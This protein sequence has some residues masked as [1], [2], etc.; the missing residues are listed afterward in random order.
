[1]ELAHLIAFNLALLVAIASPGPSLLLLTRTSVIQ[2][3]RTGIA[4]ALG[5]GL[6][7]ALW[8]LAA[9]LGLDGLFRLFPWAYAGLKV[10]GACVLL[11][12]AWTAWRSART[13]VGTSPSHLPSRHRAFLTGVL[14]NLGNPKSVFFSA[15][16]L[17]VIFPPGLGTEEKALIFL[18]HLAV[19]CLVQPALAVVL[20]T[21]AVSRGYLAAKP[22][23]DRVSAAVLGAL[24]LRLLLER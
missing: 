10:V 22:I 20:S 2:G 3:R 7:A 1:M 16:V 14:L 5:L 19:E 18:N 15:A 23:F 11:W 9:L 21:N 17:V 24:G 13:P 6:M 8:T 4:T 12:F